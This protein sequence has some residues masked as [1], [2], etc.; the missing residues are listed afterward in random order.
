MHV[1]HAAED[2]I[3]YIRIK[4]KTHSVGN[5]IFINDRETVGTIRVLKLIDNLLILNK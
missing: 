1:L 4:A 3:D 2:F 5:L